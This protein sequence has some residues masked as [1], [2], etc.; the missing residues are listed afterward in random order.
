M[1]NNT[2]EPLAIGPVLAVTTGTQVLTTLGALAL[3]AVAPKAAAE[4]GTSPALIG[5]QGAIVYFAALAAPLFG[6]GLVRTLG[7]ARTS[8]AG[9]ALVTLG[10]IVSTLGSLTAIALG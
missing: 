8:Q 10:C 4:L 7:A 9:L 1:K 6:G 3:A 2:A 5:Y